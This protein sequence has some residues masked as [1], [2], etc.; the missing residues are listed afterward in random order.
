MVQYTVLLPIFHFPTIRL[1]KISMYRYAYIQPN[2]PFLDKTNYHIN[3]TFLHSLLSKP[4]F[5]PKYT[6]HQSYICPDIYNGRSIINLML[7]IDHWTLN[8]SNFSSVK[9]H[10]Q[11]NDT[12]YNVLIYI[13]KTTFME[14]YY[15]VK[16]NVQMSWCLIQ[17]STTVYV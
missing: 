14:C 1:A 10:L 17:K 16:L 6:A 13:N 4:Y 9:N 7:T 15:L 12:V 5:L 3:Y 8:K 2:Q 11:N